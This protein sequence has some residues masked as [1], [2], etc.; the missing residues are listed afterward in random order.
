MRTTLFLS[1]AAAGIMAVSCSS[2]K[3]AAT[4]ND[5]T[6]EWN[7]TGINGTSVKTSAGEETPY[8]GFDTRNGTVN[9]FAGCNRIMGSFDKNAAPGT[10]SLSKMGATRMMCP[11]MSLENSLLTALSS[12]KGYALDRSGNLLLTGQDGKTLVTLAKRPGAQ[13]METLLGKWEIVELNDSVLVRN[14][15]EPYT[16]EFEGTDSTF[17]AQTGCNNVGGKFNAEYTAV[18]FSDIMQTRMMCPD[19]T[20]EN[21]LV[22]TLPGI[23]SFGELASGN[24]GFYDK[25]NNLVMILKK[26]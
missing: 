13:G 9:G 8:I 21:Y 17:I 11:D 25:E 1:L 20:V 24:Y 19:M 18:S 14:P 10:I 23:T 12:V 3:K 7:I 6:G 5:L 22:K 15:D 2:G 16:L 4:V 26:Q